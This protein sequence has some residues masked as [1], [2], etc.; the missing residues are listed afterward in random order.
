MRVISLP[1]EKVY[2]M[3]HRSHSEFAREANDKIAG[4]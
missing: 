1:K 3:V 2:V 4:G